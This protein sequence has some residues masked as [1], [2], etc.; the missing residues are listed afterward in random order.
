MSNELQIFSRDH[1]QRSFREVMVIKREEKK[2]RAE[3]EKGKE[4]N[5]TPSVKPIPRDYL[6]T[7]E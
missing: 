2:K 4:K 7:K 6:E 1:F 3:K 5:V